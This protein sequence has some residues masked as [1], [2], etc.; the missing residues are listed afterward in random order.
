MAEGS[1]KTS[2]GIQKRL[3]RGSP[4]PAPPEG[5]ERELAG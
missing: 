2:K 3:K 1:D 5:G 4:P